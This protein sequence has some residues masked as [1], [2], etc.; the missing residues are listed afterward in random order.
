MT[1]YGTIQDTLSHD[2]DRATTDDT[3]TLYLELMQRCLTR[4]IY[5]EPKLVNLK[6]KN[7]VKHL[8]VNAFARG[9]VQLV[10]EVR[11]HPY[12]FDARKSC[13]DLPSA[14]WFPHTML[15]LKRLDN[16]Q[17]CVEDVLAHGVPGDLIETGVWRGGAVIFMRAVLKAHNVTDRNVWVADSFEGFPRGMPEKYAEDVGAEGLLA[18]SIDEVKANFASYGLLDDQVKF[19]KGWFCDTLPTAPISSLAIA[20]LDCDQYGSTTDALTHL[21][22]KLSLGGYL[23]IDDYGGL[24]ASCRDAV[25]DFRKAH[26]ITEEIRWVDEIG[27]YWQRTR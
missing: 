7:F 26:N 12:D 19:L 9:G 14:H 10:R 18:V 8:I 4:G 17:A 23:L 11:P 13:D 25:S 5:R 3:R 24:P 1:D 16:I 15:S 22:P 6:G 27:V 20:R 21:Y 2:Y